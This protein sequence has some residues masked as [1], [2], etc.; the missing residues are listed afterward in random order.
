[1]YG[2]FYCRQRSRLGGKVWRG[3]SQ[4]GEKRRNRDTNKTGTNEA[5]DKAG[6]QQGTDRCT[7]TNLIYS[8]Y[9]HNL[10]HENVNTGNCQDGSETE[11]NIRDGS[12]QAYDTRDD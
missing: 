8:L 12:K 11:T 5:D 1:M 3:L 7:P 4:H 6:D 2:S 10:E 9:R